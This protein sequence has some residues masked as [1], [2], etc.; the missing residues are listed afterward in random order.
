MPDPS[1]PN[2]L[3]PLSGNPRL[4]ED[5]FAVYAGRLS[6]GATSTEVP[7]DEANSKSER[8]LR[9]FCQQGCGRSVAQ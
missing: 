1:S 6:W 9:S 4:Y 8:R 2:E 3:G 5:W 7:H